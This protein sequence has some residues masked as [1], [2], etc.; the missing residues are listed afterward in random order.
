MTETDPGQLDVGIMGT[1]DPA[2]QCL[3]PGDI[4][5]GVV[6]RTCDKPGIA[7]MQIFRQF[8]IDG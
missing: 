8:A 5:I 2:A 7:L 6:A 4:A 1:A 3:D